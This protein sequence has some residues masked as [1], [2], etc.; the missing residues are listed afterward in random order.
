MLT[1]IS[2]RGSIEIAG[3]RLIRS[4]GNLVSTSRRAAGEEQHDIHN[5]AQYEDDLDP[6]WDDI[7]R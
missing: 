1:N 4:D 7:D 3:N 6:I 5:M 2:P